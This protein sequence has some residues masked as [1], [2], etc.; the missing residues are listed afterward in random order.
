MIDDATVAF[1]PSFGR[2]QTQRGIFADPRWGLRR[3]YRGLRSD[4]KAAILNAL[5]ESR[6]QFNT[7]RVTPHTPI[8]GSFATSELLTNNTFA[9]GTTGWAAGSEYSIS[10]SDRV[11]AGVRSAMTAASTIASQTVGITQYAPYVGRVMVN[12]GRGTYSSVGLLLSGSFSF[13]ASTTPGL[14]SALMVGDSGASASFAI[15]DAATSGLQAGDYVRVPYTSFARCALVDNGSNLL[16][17]SDEFDN[18]SW[19][20][21][22][23]TV[24]ANGAVA[25]DG[26]STADLLV[27][28]SS[29][30]SHAVSQ[31]ATVSSSAGDY[32]FV[33]AVKANVRS[34]CVLSMQENS[35]STTVDQYFNLGTGAVG[36]TGATGA[37]WANRR[38]FIVSLGSGWYLC[39]LVARKTNSAT[40]I[41]PVLLAATADGTSSYLGGGNTALFAWRATL[42]QSA[43]PVRPSQTVSA[44]TTG[45]AQT[46]AALYTKGWPVSTSGLLLTGDWFEINGEL[47]QLTAPVNSDAAGLAYMQFRPGL[48][49]SPADNDPVVVFEPFGR[50]IYPQGT[51]ELENLF[52]IYGDCE[53]NLEEIYS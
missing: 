6:G 3:R 11:L 13:S 17:R 40:Q 1:Q 23:L 52:G 48:A 16:V 31:A 18:A 8:R 19:T 21:T 43:V 28:N 53:M 20:K 14:I 12:S 36:S 34:F 10:V 9:S 47:K 49:G 39:C 2:G 45:T 44:S 38:A 24:T 7:I 25:P 32:A 37:N 15:R 30:G 22:N 51:R 4:E 27:E 42:A 41:A 33:V 26:T 5:N 46:G 35:G 29:S 50:F